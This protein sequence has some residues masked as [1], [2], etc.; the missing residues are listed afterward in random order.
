MNPVEI[1]K[2]A[3]ESLFNKSM[4]SIITKDL[5]VTGIGS[6]GLNSILDGIVNLIK[7]EIKYG[8]KDSV[9]GIE[10]DFLPVFKIIKK[11]KD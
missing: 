7:L 3:L 9:A 6:A 1:V 8:I 4:V 5:N 10:N 2:N 11:E